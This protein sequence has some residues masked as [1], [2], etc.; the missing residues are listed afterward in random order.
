V[1]SERKKKGWM[2]M[3]SKMIDDGESMIGVR[4]DSGV[5]GYWHDGE[6][7]RQESLRA[8]IGLLVSLV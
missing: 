3:I 5:M 1:K 8:N 2:E 6:N 7:N 4:W